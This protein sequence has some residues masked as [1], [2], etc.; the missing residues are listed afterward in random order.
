MV[1]VMAIESAVFGRCVEG[2]FLSVELENRGVWLC[3]GCRYL[4]F[5]RGGKAAQ[6]WRWSRVMVP[7]IGNRFGCLRMIEEIKSPCHH[8]GF[9]D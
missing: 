1:S 8:R 9:W 3:C 5:I 4:S 2:I 7:G 6:N